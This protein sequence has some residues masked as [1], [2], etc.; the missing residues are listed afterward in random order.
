MEHTH[1]RMTVGERDRVL[2][3][4]VPARSNEHTLPSHILRRDHSGRIVAALT[5]GSATA[6]ANHP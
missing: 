1:A 2:S 5:G 6:P 4:P 3:P